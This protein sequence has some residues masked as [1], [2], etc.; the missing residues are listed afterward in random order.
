MTVSCTYFVAVSMVSGLE[1]M[2][3]IGRGVLRSYANDGSGAQLSG[4]MERGN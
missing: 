3:N 1:N 2:S 4:Y